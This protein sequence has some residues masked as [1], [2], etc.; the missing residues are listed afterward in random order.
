MAPL[1]NR[2]NYVSL[3]SVCTPST[4]WGH[5]K[6]F[7][8]YRSTVFYEAGALAVHQALPLWEQGE[9]SGAVSCEETKHSEQCF[10]FSTVLKLMHI[11]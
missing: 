8:K 3:T 10:N 6:N 2:T 7:H 4:H 1:P 5:S 9:P 11:Y